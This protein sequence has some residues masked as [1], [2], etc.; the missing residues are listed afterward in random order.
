M[1]EILSPTAVRIGGVKFTTA[2]GAK[3][4]CY[5]RC[6]AAMRGV[7]LKFTNGLTLSVQWGS[8]NYCSARY[9][10]GFPLDSETAEIGVWDRNGMWLCDVLGW[11]GSAD[12]LALI[13]YLMGQDPDVTGVY[14]STALDRLAKNAP[15]PA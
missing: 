8:G 13:P 4:T 11:L 3:I 12:V 7:H 6:D 2:S 10:D 14:P 5:E 9:E 15:V 1:F